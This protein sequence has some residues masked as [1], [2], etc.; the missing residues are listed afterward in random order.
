MRTLLRKLP[1]LAL[2]WIAAFAVMLGAL[3][4]FLLTMPRDDSGVRRLF[5][6]PDLREAADLLVSSNAGEFWG[7]FFAMFAA[8]FVAQMLFL[9]P[10]RRPRPNVTG[11]RSVWLSLVV[12]ALAIGFLIFG[13]LSALFGVI[14]GAENPFKEV[15]PI[16]LAI[17][18]GWL[19]AFP[20]LWAFAGR[21]PRRPREEFL[22][23]IAARLLL[24]TIIEVAALIPLDVMLRRRTNCYCGEATFLPLIACGALGVFAFGPAIY[25]PLLARRRRRW[26]AQH[27]DACGYDMTA[28]PRAERC[29]ECGAGWKPDDAGSMAPEHVY[30]S[31]E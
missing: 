27:C 24:G 28:C 3:L 29:P 2:Y 31:H 26:Y 12:A 11:G 1:F 22:R 10:V 4:A 9:L 19:A 21:G 13:A 23:R 17:G 5:G 14:S 25:L 7:V 6:T 16:V 18:I 8:T 30:G 15:T 20:L